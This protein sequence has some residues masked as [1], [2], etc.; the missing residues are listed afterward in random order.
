MLP[1]RLRGGGG[2][3][4]V[5]AL[6][7]VVEEVPGLEERVFSLFSAARRVSLAE[8][9][10]GLEEKIDRGDMLRDACACKESGKQ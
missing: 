10:L 5:A 6:E 3:C 1:F 9:D 2:C 8:E 4:C 7:V